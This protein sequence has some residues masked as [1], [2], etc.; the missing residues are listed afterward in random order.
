MTKA[1][2]RLTLNLH[3]SRFP[4]VAAATVRVLRQRTNHMQPVA[5]PSRELQFEFMPGSHLSWC[6]RS[7][8]VSSRGMPQNTRKHGGFPR[9]CSVSVSI[10]LAGRWFPGADEGECLRGRLW[11]CPLFNG[12]CRLSH[13]SQCSLHLE[14]AE[15]KSVIHVSGRFCGWVKVDNGQWLYMRDQLSKEPPAT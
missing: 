7:V 13:D 11:A 2:L 12:L 9:G 14:S 15:R 8:P 6:E 5:S 4:A 1:S 10:D 3:G